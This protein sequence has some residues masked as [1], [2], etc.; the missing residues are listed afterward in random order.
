MRKSCVYG[1]QAPFVDALTGCPT[2]YKGVGINLPLTST[3]SVVCRFLTLFCHQFINKK[4]KSTCSFIILS[5]P[6]AERQFIKMNIME[7]LKSIVLSFCLENTDNVELNDYT[8]LIV[9]LGF[10]SITLVQ[11]VVYVEDEFGIEFDDEMLGLEGIVHFDNLAE[12][13]N[14]KINERTCNNELE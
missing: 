13:V 4:A 11:L 12:Y 9:D 7:K 1:L 6:S 8:D 10:D 5:V 2:P 3:G 14:K